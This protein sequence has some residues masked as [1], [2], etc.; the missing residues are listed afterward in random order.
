MNVWRAL[1]IFAFAASPAF[2]QQ[3]GELSSPYSFGGACQSQGMWTIDASRALDQVRDV[4]LKM[5]ADPNCGALSS[6]LEEF[7]KTLKEQNKEVAGSATVANRLSSFR[8]EIESIVKYAR[9][10]RYTQSKI[11]EALA[12]KSIDA[13]LMTAEAR[14]STTDASNAIDAVSGD[15][16]SLGQR[17]NR[18]ANLGLDTMNN[19]FE[20][21]LSESQCL[22]NPNFMGPFMSSMIQMTNAFMGSGQDSFGTKTSSLANNIAKFLL[23]NKKYIDTNNI[24]NQ[25]QFRNSMSCLLETV[26]ES[27]CS[28]LDAE[29]LYQEHIREN[30][31]Q[32]DP[33][34]GVI[35]DKSVLAGRLN[36]P[37]RGFF[38]LT[39][40]V[41]IVTTWIE[42]VQRGVEPRNSADANF[43]NNIL[44]NTITY[45][46]QENDLLSIINADQVTVRKLPDQNAKKRQVLKTIMN[47]ASTI[48]GGRD[49]VVGLNFYTMTVL[50]IEIP[51]KLLGIAVPA[52]VAG[53]LQ[54]G[55]MQDGGQYLQA[56]ID[57]IPEFNDPDGLLA[58][59]LVNLRTLIRQAE[60]N[61]IAY[62][63]EWFIYDQAS[64]YV[65]S[66][67]GFTYNVRDAIQHIDS[68][69]NYVQSRIVLNKEM[70]PS[71]LPMI[72]DTHRRL[73]SVLS[74]YEDLRLLGETFKSTPATDKVARD[75]L[76]DRGKDLHVKLLETAYDE[77]M[78]MKARSGFLLG[79]VANIVK[80][81]LQNLLRMNPSDTNK[82]AKDIFYAS[83]DAAFERMKMMSGGN[84]YFIYS[85]IKTAQMTHLENLEAIETLLRDNFVR[86][87]AWTKMIARNDRPGNEDVMHDS[88]NRLIE[89]FSGYYPRSDY[90][91]L[92]PF[93]WIFSPFRM[94]SIY[95]HHSDRYSLMGSNPV[96]DLRGKAP[97]DSYAAITTD[98]NDTLYPDEGAAE[99]ML[100]HYCIQ[101][102]AFKDSVPFKNLCSNITL[103]SPFLHHEMTPEEKD[104]YYY[105][106]VDGQKVETTA[107]EKAKIRH[108]LLKSDMKALLTAELSVNY[109]TKSNQFLSPDVF[110]ALKGND[111]SMKVEARK[112]LARNQSMRVCALREFAR[113][114]FVQY[115]TQGFGTK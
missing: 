8:S 6:R 45:Y 77:F 93:F 55:F 40:L 101:S 47:L 87:M 38:V 83:G 110:A 50:P 91:R 20:S 112:I 84:P 22:Q 79:R 15:L 68:Y 26:S 63:N 64:Q 9:S 57:E 72:E 52:E 58:N 11:Q 12:Q 14:K 27:Y 59:A 104:R 61:A 62:Y 92:N 43:K 71:V 100:S 4:A 76:V 78:I 17:V 80:Y 107:L 70:D 33:K 103:H 31:Y 67:T 32:R 48:T 109:Q 115:L 24:L 95:T 90:S 105:K 86:S 51:F 23:V 21:A 89:D 97:Y 19:L 36:S 44:R 2:A 53:K 74:K 16:Q 42:K 41:P 99:R 37:L 73:Q 39:Q 54:S 30:G 60:Q 1:I 25:A 65:D 96:W 49:E 3:A 108:D 94:I 85:D 82:I 75:A 46:I 10:G 34:T 66:V 114:N 35:T 88:I 56:H 113:N 7:Y 81:D 5:K 69:F 18:S 28:T 106:T 13:A 102:L 29:V 111:D 98:D